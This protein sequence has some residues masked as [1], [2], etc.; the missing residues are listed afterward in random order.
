MRAFSQDPQ[1]A[2]EGRKRAADAVADEMIVGR[3]KG[4]G[5]QKGV[6]GEGEGEGE[7]VSVASTRRLLLLR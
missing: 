2:F 1:K 5:R 4:G 7:R 6:E 3:R